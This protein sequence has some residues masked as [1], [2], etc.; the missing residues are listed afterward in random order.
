MVGPSSASS[1]S[2]AAGVTSPASTATAAAGTA[3]A[4]SETPQGRKMD[5]TSTAASRASATARLT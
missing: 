5:V 4:A 1:A 3:N 2:A